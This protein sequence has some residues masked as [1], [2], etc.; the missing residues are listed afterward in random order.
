MKPKNKFLRIASFFTFPAI[1][2]FLNMFLD[3]GL[4]LY[5][6]FPLLNAPMHFVG[7]LSVGYMCILFLRFF[8]EEK[9][10][11]IK[12]KFVFVLIVVA[13]VGLIAVL[14]EFYEYAMVYVF[15]VNW[16]MTYGDTLLDLG[17]GIFGGFVAGML[18]G[19]V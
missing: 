12:N 17:M 3:F 11:E 9:I 13:L 7:G 18:F 2:Y 15:G 4:K 1:V 10:M 8:E 14:W 19:R 6:V 16:V 5:D